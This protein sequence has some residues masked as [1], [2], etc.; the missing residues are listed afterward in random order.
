MFSVL[1]VIKKETHETSQ[2]KRIKNTSVKTG[3]FFYF[4]LK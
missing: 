3:V 1:S 4:I 2:D